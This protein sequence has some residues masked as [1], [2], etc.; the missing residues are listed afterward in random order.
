LHPVIPELVKVELGTAYSQVIS[1]LGKP[2]EDVVTK[3][4]ENV[5]R[6]LRYYRLGMFLA[7]QADD[8]VTGIQINFVK[9][10]GGKEGAYPLIY[11]AAQGGHVDM[12]EFLI[13]QGA[14][15]NASDPQLGCT[16]L[17]GAAQEGK[18][19]MTRFLLSKGAKINATDRTGAT[20]LH[21]AAWWGRADAA[22]VLI[23][24]GAS[25]NA[26]DQKGHTPLAVALERKNND[27]VELLRKAGAK[28]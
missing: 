8:K 19:E 12:A 18:A 14:D 22:Q 26:T 2:D 28:E 17:H 10:G 11:I 24:S 25:V 15:V 5:G 16:P 27:V 3:S 20:P 1:A 6:R 23:A 7:F 21:K 9:P 13:A 4:E